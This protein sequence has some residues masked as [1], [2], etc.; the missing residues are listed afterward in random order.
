MRTFKQYAEGLAGQYEKAIFP[1]PLINQF[2]ASVEGHPDAAAEFAKYLQE[3]IDNA[4][5]AGVR[6]ENV[7]K[8]RAMVS[9]NGGSFGRLLK[10]VWNFI[11]AHGPGAETTLK[12]FRAGSTN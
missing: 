9:K 10:G 1:A 2:T 3:I 12:G 8:A 6:A 7:A 5:S 11:A 4:E